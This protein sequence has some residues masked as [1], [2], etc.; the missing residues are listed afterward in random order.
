MA[1]TDNLLAFYK[2]DDL[3]DSSGNGN[4]LTNNG[5]VSFSSGKIG[6]AA[7]FDG[8]NELTTTNPIGQGAE[9]SLTAWV[10]FLNFDSFQ[11]ILSFGND[12]GIVYHD[13]VNPPEIIITPEYGEWRGVGIPSTNEWHFIYAY[14][15][16]NGEYGIS[17]DNGSLYTGNAGERYH[18]S[19]HLG[20]LLD[21]GQIDGVGIWSRALTE[22]E[23]AELYN[24]GTGVELEVLPPPYTI[25]ISGNAKMFGNVKFA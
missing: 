10:K 8:T 16:P 19:I 18:N 2:L 5:D 23:I 3:T 13:G 11:W 12:V 22:S 15:K 6:N 9:Y 21:N 24:S 4:T 25:R 7:V 1:L 20:Y 14:R 17:I